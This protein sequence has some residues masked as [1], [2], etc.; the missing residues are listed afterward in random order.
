MP[1]RDTY[2][3]YALEQLAKVTP[4][5]WRRMFGAVG[6]YADGVFFAILDND[7]LYLRTGE[8]N[9]GEYE[10]LGMR[11]FQPMGPD[12]KPMAYHELPGDV[13]EDVGR[14]EGWVAAA[15]EQARRAHQARP[16][17]RLKRPRAGGSR[18]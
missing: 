10:R 17:R 14:L 3:D 5:T 7:L 8:G 11:A 12:T 16:S 2:R 15:V 1:V 6:V 9:R 4:V 18:A 13:L